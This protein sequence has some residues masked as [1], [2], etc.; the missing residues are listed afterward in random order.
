[1]KAQQPTE[2]KSETRGLKQDLKKINKPAQ[3]LNS[4]QSKLMDLKKKFND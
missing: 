4:F 1:M 3:H 2:K